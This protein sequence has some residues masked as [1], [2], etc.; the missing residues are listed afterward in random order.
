MYYFLTEAMT[1]RFV[2]EL[3]AFWVTQAKFKDLP[4]YIQ[5]KFSFKERPQ[6]GIIVKATGGSQTSLAF[7]N[8]KGTVYSY[9]HLT[10]VKN[11]FGSA[12]EW[13]RE[14][15]LAIQRNQGL[16]PS[17]PGIYYI[18]ITPSSELLVQPILDV[19][20][21]ELLRITDSTWQFSIVPLPNTTRV[22]EMPS[23]FRL[24]DDGYTIDG[25]GLLTLTEPLPGNVQLVVDYRYTGEIKG[26]VPIYEQQANN[27]IIPGVVL[28]FGTSIEPNDQMAVVVEAS[29]TLAALAYGGRWE[30]TV[31]CDVVARDVHDQREILDKSVMYLWGVARNR[32]STEGIEML[33]I[34]MG[35]ESEEQYDENGDDYFY[36][37]S[38]SLSCETEWE[39]HVPLDVIIREVDPVT[40]AQTK[41]ILSLTDEEVIGYETNI[42]LLGQM[43]LEP[44][45]KT[46]G[47]SR[48]GTF[49]AFK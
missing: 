3:Q 48:L 35:G 20:G 29:R 8:F 19:Y 21:E 44:I 2:K 12:I 9:V 47:F 36:N 22:Y 10:K 18:T 30:I 49:E 41:Q 1:R 7:D 16:F 31:D 15:A 14:D 37:A 38:F 17:P 23:G 45:A 33:S 5:G 11:K 46:I 25:D 26:P 40:A 28:A 24:P 4:E 42:R 32:L 43:S 6:R 34:S 27:Q 13:V 39:I